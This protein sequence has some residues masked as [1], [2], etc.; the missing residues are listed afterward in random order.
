[1]L[2][3]NV[4][5]RGSCEKQ[6]LIIFVFLLEIA[7][8]H[9]SVVFPPLRM[10]YKRPVVSDALSFLV[11]SEFVPFWSFLTLLRRSKTTMGGTKNI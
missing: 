1:M 9:C 6:R 7:S 11:F 2:S 10:A 3:N 4:S 8:Q 5:M